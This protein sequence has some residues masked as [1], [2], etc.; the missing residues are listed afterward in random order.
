MTSEGTAGDP[1]TDA[2][3]QSEIELV[4]DLVA[5]ASESKGPLGEREIDRLLGV[6]P[7]E[8]E[9]TGG[10]PSHSHPGQDPS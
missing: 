2:A 1:L 8:D 10:E 6:P 3:L 9:P 4:G 5:A 7:E